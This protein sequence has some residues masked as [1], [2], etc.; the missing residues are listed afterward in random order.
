MSIIRKKQIFKAMK[1]RTLKSVK[2][3]SSEIKRVYSNLVACIKNI[4]VLV[5]ILN[6]SYKTHAYIL[7][8]SD[9][10]IFVLLPGL[11]MIGYR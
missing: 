5:K 11:V 4:S 10:D 1:F 3:Y 7:E 6:G 2:F 9:S 8:Q